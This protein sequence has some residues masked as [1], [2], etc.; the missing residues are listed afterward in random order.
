MTT[1]TARRDPPTLPIE[2]ACGHVTNA[3][4]ILYGFVICTGYRCHCSNPREGLYLWR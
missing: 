4:A 3:H 1:L 2:C